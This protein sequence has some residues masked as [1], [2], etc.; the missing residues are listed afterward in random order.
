MLRAA[1]ISTLTLLVLASLTGCVSRSRERAD[2]KSAFRAGEQKGEA[3]AEAKRNGISFT[4]QVLVP[5]VPWTEGLTL[6]DA[7]VAAH[8]TGLHDPRLII[9][10]NRNGERMELMPEEAVM[11]GELPLAPGDTIELVP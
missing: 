7:I 1:Q 9:V 2:L 8:W 11:A 5:I 3:L 10:T 4:G 6:A